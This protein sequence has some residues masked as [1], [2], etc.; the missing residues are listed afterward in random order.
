MFRQSCKGN[1]HVF[2]RLAGIFDDYYDEDNVEVGVDIFPQLVDN[3]LGKIEDV[4]CQ[5]DSLLDCGYIRL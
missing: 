4:F 3:P 1:F 2:E 5:C